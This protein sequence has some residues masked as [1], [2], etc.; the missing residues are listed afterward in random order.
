MADFHLRRASDT[1]GGG[2]PLGGKSAAAF[3]W[4]GLLL[5][6]KGAVTL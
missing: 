6:A 3:F 1:T 5:Y 2:L 4:Q